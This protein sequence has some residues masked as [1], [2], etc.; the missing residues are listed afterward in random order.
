MQL[1]AVELRRLEL[2]LVRPMATSGGRHE[3]RP[4]VLVRVETDVGEGWGECAALAAPTYTE[5]YADGAERVLAEVLVPILLRAGRGLAGAA[6]ALREL[7]VVRGHRMAKA[8]LEMALLDVELRAA[9]RSL[10]SWLGATRQSI[11]AGATVGTGA[12]DA[13]VAEVG[14]AVV[15]GFTRV[16]CKVAP[17]SDVEQLRAVRASFPGLVVAVD[18]NGAY[19]LEVAEH[20]AAL[21]ELDGLGLAAIEQP[22]APDDLVGHR[23]LTA[24]LATPVVLDES[25]T[26]VGAL[27]AAL[28]LRAC[29]GV[30]VKAARL[31]GVLVA[32]QVHDRCRA[33][34]VR[35]AAGGMLETGLGRAVALAIAALPGFDLPGDVGP[36]DRYFSPDITA[37]HVL[38]D[39]A[40]AVPS[41]AGI[42]V[43]P[44]DEVVEAATVRVATIRAT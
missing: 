33:A 42:G 22:L 8:A 25:V 10:A 43:A 20:R 1:L 35:L 24:A 13:V 38:V 44:V 27:E 12:P 9:G 17:G 39:G 5:E 32:L 34:G 29:D 36:T 7:A 11:V 6:D 31:G 37:P 26:G 14:A 21:G 18:A 30:S 41:G 4:V 2:E 16:K 23:E 15:A 40:I 28:A 3:R 19:R